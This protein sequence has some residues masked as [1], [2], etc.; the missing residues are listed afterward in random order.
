[1]IN[2]NNF[3]FIITLH[4]A[5]THIQNLHTY[6]VKWIFILYFNLFHTHT[7]TNA[8]KD[9]SYKTILFSQFHIF[10]RK[11]FSQSHELKKT[12]SEMRFREWYVGSQADS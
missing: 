4:S 10:T 9:F 12:K 3:Q 5:L 2:N 8:F 6:C 11:T 1:M 7:H